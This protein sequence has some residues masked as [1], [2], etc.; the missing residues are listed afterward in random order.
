MRI[1]PESREIG[2]ILIGIPEA[3]LGLASLV[4]TA[5]HFKWNSRPQTRPTSVQHTLPEAVSIAIADSS[6]KM[7]IDY[8][9]PPEAIAASLLLAGAL[10]CADAARRFGRIL[11]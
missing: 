2:T 6:H 1:S 3:T 5:A 11:P 4:T 7:G 9:V 8:A 10:L